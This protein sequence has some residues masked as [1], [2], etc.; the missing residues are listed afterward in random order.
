MRKLIYSIVW[1]TAVALSTTV[2]EIQACTTQFQNTH[3]RPA[4]IYCNISTACPGVDE[5]C[6]SG[7]C[8]GGPGGPSCVGWWQY[9]VYIHYCG[10]W[11]ACGNSICA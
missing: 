6:E 7:Q 5:A 2:H 10:L 1:L 9:C 8:S 3:L 11:S 4:G